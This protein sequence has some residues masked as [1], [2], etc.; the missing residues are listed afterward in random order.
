MHVIAFDW[1]WTVD[2]DPHPEHEGVPLAWITGLVGADEYRV[3]ALSDR[4]ARELGIPGP[5][6]ILS[7]QNPS[8]S[9]RRAILEQL[10]ARHPD[11]TSRTV[12]DDIDMSDVAGWAHYTGWEFV[13]AARAETLPFEVPDITH[14]TEE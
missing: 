5:Q 12:V 8:G 3:Y 14:E 4:L 11:A 9:E 13:A 10:R 2:Q 7:E 6:T 1:G